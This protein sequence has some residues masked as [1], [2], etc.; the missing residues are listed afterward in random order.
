MCLG[1]VEVLNPD[2]LCPSALVLSQ[3]KKHFLPILESIKAFS[4]QT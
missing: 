4:P 3:T 1:F 2:I